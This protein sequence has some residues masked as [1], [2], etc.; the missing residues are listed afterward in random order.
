[1]K[2][3]RHFTRSQINTERWNVTIE[4]YNLTHPYALSWYLDVVAPDWEALVLGD[5][6]VI[7]PLPVSRKLG[8]KYIYQ[9]YYCQQLGL[10]GG[11]ADNDTYRSFCERMLDIAPY[12]DYNFNHLAPFIDP[13]LHRRNNF[14]L[15]LAPGAEVLKSG[16]STNLARNIKKAIKARFAPQPCDL[17]AFLT[18]YKANN[19][20]KENLKNKHEPIVYNLWAELSKRQMAGV[21]GVYDSHNQ[22]LAAT[23]LVMYK[24]RVI[25]LINTS[26]PAGRKAGANHL[27]LSWVI[28]N[29]AGNN[30]V[31]DF[32]GSSVPG[33]M[34]FYSSFGPK[35]E[36]YPNLNTNILRTKIGRAHV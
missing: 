28:E 27:L 33:V 19:A 20:E 3:I 17:E 18:F 1:M 35:N 8:I 2:E 34:G 30:M 23:F 12:I 13:L 11:K 9:P 36:P 4:K 22:L 10:F 26:D 7:M 15:N 31:F 21:Y 5:Y 32:E 29:Y 14:V 24:N 25:N 6:E 16:Y